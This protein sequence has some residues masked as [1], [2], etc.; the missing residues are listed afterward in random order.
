MNFLL[1]TNHKDESLY[2]IIVKLVFDL[3]K[4]RHKFYSQKWSLVC[5][6]IYAFWVDGRKILLS[7]KASLNAAWN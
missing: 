7:S 5:N 4:E 2:S 3:N 6:L 1:D